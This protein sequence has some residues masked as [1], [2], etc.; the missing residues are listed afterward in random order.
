MPS[1]VI[2]KDPSIRESDVDEFNPRRF[3]TL[4]AENGE[5]PTKAAFRAFGGG[6]TLC[7]GRHF[8]T[9]ETLAVVA[10]FVLRYD[11]TPTAEAGWK[12]PETNNTNVAAVIMKVDTDIEVEIS[13]RKELEEGQ[14]TIVLR[15]PEMVFAVVAE[16]QGE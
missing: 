8:A 12:L 1:R 14:S 6:T 13:Q 3:M 5:R 9:N 16:D 11:M 10:M 15:V 7:P 2:H 4:R